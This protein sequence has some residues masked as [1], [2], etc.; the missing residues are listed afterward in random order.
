MRQEKLKF[1]IKFEITVTGR[2]YPYAR[3]NLILWG[4]ITCSLILEIEEVD[5]HPTR[6]RKKRVRDH[7]TYP[8]F[9]GYV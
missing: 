1:E 2:G 7:V 4:I 6:A 9:G 3:I 8:L 5:T